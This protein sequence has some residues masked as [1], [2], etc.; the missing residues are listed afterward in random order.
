MGP[1]TAQRLG[2]SLALGFVLAGAPVAR[3]WTR[4][5]DLDEDLQGWAGWI[6]QG[7]LEDLGSGWRDWRFWF[8]AQARWRAD[9]ETFDLTV[10]RP[11]IGY[12]LD[13]HWTVHVGYG[14]IQTHPASGTQVEHRPWEQLQWRGPVGD[15]NLISRSRL[16]QRFIEDRGETGWRWRQMLRG[17]A[18]VFGVSSPFLAASDELFF[19]L[20]DTSWGQRDGLRQN[21]AFA[22]LGWF[23]NAAK[24]VSLEVGYLNQW[25]DRPDEDRM[26][27]AI[28]INL[29]TNF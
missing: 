3:G 28:S 6:A 11:G 12:A 8:D 10:L 21:R 24:T 29:F 7:S 25:L 2:V 9:L 18:P 14:W 27:H 4:P 13:K 16:E 20:N 1:A 17:T 19:D 15:W 22:G 5:A 23:L 26:N